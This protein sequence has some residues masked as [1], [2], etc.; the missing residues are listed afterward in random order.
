MSPKWTAG[1]RVASCRSGLTALSVAIRDWIQLACHF[2]EIAGCCIR[3]SACEDSPR[4]RQFPELHLTE[5]F[6]KDYTVWK[7]CCTFVLCTGV[8][9]GPKHIG[10]GTIG[11]TGNGSR[12][13]RKGCEGKS[14]FERN[15]H[16]SLSRHMYTVNQPW[17]REKIPGWLHYDTT[18]PLWVRLRGGSMY[19]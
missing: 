14:V 16:C 1:V 7:M 12:D 15:S 13:I 2:K 4:C 18:L 11:R 19:Q 8:H 5:L 9:P 17:S 10:R 6:P 3:A